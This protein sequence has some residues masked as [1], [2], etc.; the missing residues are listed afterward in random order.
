MNTNSNINTAVEVIDNI[1]DVL[2][3]HE[4]C[5]LAE[6]VI[7]YDTGF[8]KG[9][10]NIEISKLCKQMLNQQFVLSA[11]GITSVTI[12]LCCGI[13]CFAKYGSRKA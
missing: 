8:V 12:V 1:S 13:Y 11:L 4:Y 2:T 3:C 9:R 10:N 7:E 6:K 5:I